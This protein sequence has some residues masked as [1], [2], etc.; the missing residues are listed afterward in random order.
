MLGIFAA[1]SFP[2]GPATTIDRAAT[3]NGVMFQIFNHGLT[4]S[5]MF[6]FVALLEKRSGGLRGLNDFGGLRKVAPIF[7]GLMGITIFSS[8]GLP[9]LGGFVGEFLILKG[10]FPFAPWAVALSIL[11]LGITAIFLLTILQRVF[12]G[13][14]KEKW[15]DFPDLTKTDRI[16]IALPVILMFVIGIYPQLLIRIINDTTM[17]LIQQLGV[18]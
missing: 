4:S 6:W 16:I 18:S 12:S 5:T 11:G 3:L 9:G 17:R 7:S 13:P 15:L 14:L 2:F 8:L 10:V 1:V